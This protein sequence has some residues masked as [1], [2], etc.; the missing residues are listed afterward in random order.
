MIV[1]CAWCQSLGRAAVLREKEPQED[2]AVSHGICDDHAVLMLAEAR[3][4]TASEGWMAL[5]AS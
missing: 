4:V 3:R 5:R 2:P 1:V